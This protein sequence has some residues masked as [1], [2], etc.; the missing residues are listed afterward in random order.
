MLD[1]SLLNYF[2]FQQIIYIFFPVDL[3][4]GQREV[5]PRGLGLSWEAY[6]PLSNQEEGCCSDQARLKITPPCWA[7]SLRIDETSV[8]SWGW[9]LNLGDSPSNNGWGML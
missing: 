1:F 6:K 7:K 5:L 9:T 2:S 3:S 8:N 4:N